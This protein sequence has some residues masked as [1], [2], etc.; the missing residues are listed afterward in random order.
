MM[1]WLQFLFE[2]KLPS[3]SRHQRSFLRATGLRCNVPF[4]PAVLLC[5]V[6]FLSTKIYDNMIKQVEG[7][8][9]SMFSVCAHCFS[10]VVF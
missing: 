1:P 6:F 8:C 5:F 4:L 10:S 7:R 9:V 3:L 2:A